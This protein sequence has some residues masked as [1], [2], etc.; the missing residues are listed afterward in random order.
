MPRFIP[1][2]FPDAWIAKDI[3]ISKGK[4]NNILNIK[5]G[6][7]LYRKKNIPSIVNRETKL[8][9]PAFV[10]FF[11]VNTPGILLGACSS[12]LIRFKKTYHRQIIIER[13]NKTGPS[14]S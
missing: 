6:M 5:E 3:H 13:I 10:L 8:S 14:D 2:R 7:K 9:M 1:F 11:I 12:S 4:T